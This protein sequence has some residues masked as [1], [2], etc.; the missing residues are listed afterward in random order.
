VG[1]ITLQE[2]E[3][4][5]KEKDE[6]TPT[7]QAAPKPSS[8][9]LIAQSDSQRG[10]NLAILLKR[11]KVPGSDLANSILS[12]NTKVIDEDMTS[13]LIKCVPTDDEVEMVQDC[14][15]NSMIG[16]V[17]KF[18][19][20]VGVIPFLDGRLKSILFHWQFD[21][22]FTDV[23]AQQ[24]ALQLATQ[25]VRS[26]KSLRDALTMILAIGN[27]LNASSPARGQAHGFDLPS[28]LKMKDTKTTSGD[29]TLL[30]YVASK[31]GRPLISSLV[32]EFSVLEKSR[33]LDIDQMKQEL[34]QLKESFVLLRTTLDKC[35][36]SPSQLKND[37][38]VSKMTPFKETVDQKLKDLEQAT[39]E[40]E[41][42]FASLQQYLACGK[43]KPQEV[44]GTFFQFSV[45]LSS[46]PTNK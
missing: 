28:L 1:G 26:S 42:G 45:E 36:N 12:V 24:E 39:I 14:L 35:K 20:D 2:L 23:K 43:S 19:L 25:T 4:L 5:F 17:E 3:K 44:F 41:Q 11:I 37:E 15:D 29:S 46:T 31:L 33:G 21:G 8:A 30:N 22:K 10:Q 13:I 38:F 34:K 9:T 16:P 6:K 18:F 7:A 40:T 27:H 32:K